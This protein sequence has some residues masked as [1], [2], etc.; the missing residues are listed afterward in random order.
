MVDPPRYGFSSTRSVLKPFLAAVLADI[1]PEIPAPITKTS[2][3]IY[4]CS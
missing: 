1:I 3:C 4:L 2:Q